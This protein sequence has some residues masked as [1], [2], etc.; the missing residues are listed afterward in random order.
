[1]VVGEKNLKKKNIVV[2][3]KKI[4]ILGQDL[5]TRAQMRLRM[6]VAVH[7]HRSCR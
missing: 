5:E 7:R 2:Y 4:I 3:T 1:V 6:L